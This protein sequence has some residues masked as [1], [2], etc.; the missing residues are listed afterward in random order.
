M[1]VLRNFRV[2][3]P[4]YVVLIMQCL[5]NV[6]T[7]WCRIVDTATLHHGHMASGVNTSSRLG[8]TSLV[9]RLSA[10]LTEANWWRLI[11]E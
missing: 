8:G 4:C 11:A 5:N 1:H 6:V 2:F 3:R 9:S 10:C 7:L